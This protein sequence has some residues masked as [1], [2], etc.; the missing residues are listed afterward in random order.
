MCPDY[1]D[2]DGPGSP[3][4]EELNEQKLF[5]YSPLLA[6]RI[7]P[8]GWKST[9]F[10]IINFA[11]FNIVCKNIG[12]FNLFVQHIH[13][14]M[15]ICVHMCACSKNQTHPE[16]GPLVILQG[17]YPLSHLPIPNF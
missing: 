9:A 16:V 10:V 2:E 12:L 3:R 14:H 1:G 8:L 4:A 7:G 6:L 15:F 11:Y 5:S 17:S 13:A